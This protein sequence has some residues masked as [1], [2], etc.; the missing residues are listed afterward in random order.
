MLVLKARLSL[1]LLLA[2]LVCVPCAQAQQTLNAS[3]S[4]TT[5]KLGNGMQVILA[6]DHSVPVVTEA[7]MVKVGSRDEQPGHA[8]FAHLFE[9]LMFE[10]SLHAP[11]G[12][13]DRLVEGYGGTDNAQTDVDYTFYFE[14]MPSNALPILMWLDSDRLAHLN[15]TQKNMNNQVAVVEEEKRYR[16]DN[17]PYGAVLYAGIPRATFRNWHNAHSVIGSFHDL[18]AATL[19]EVQAFFRT[20]YAPRNIILVIAGDFKPATAQAMV[21]HYFGAI[22][23]R[24]PAPN[25]VSTKEPKVRPQP[26]LLLQDKQAHLPEIALSWQG[27]KRHSQD[28]YAMTLLGELLFNGKSSRLYQLL[29]KRDKLAISVD[30]GLG[31]PTADYTDYRSPGIFGSSIIYKQ[32]GSAE[33]I[34][35]LVLAEIQ[36]I[37]DDGPSRSEMSMARAQIAADWIRNEETTL[38]RAQMLATAA[39]V[40]HSPAAA[41]RF[42]A[43]IN[44]VTMADVQRAAAKYLDPKLVAEVLDQPEQNGGK[45]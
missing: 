26:P 43:R 19:S 39:L 12:V 29:V 24:A 44:E 9:H 31:F 40:D 2:A 10:G 22:P 17:A 33:R 21:E 4:F 1:G 36:Q 20:Y 27:P 13:F 45:Q 38:G 5:F 11:K 25:K 28:F 6:P 42:L 8:G 14:T 16:V 23:N 32:G 30:G 37:G 41:N 34:K 35:H 3:V 7:M 15:V 18:N